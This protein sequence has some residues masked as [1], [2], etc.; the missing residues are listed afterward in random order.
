[1]TSFVGFAPADAPRYVV[2]VDLERPTGAGDG[3]GVAAPVFS[4]V[5][6][7]ALTTA[8]VVPSGTPRPNFTLIHTP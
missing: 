3:G 7:Y 8:G 6:R 2:A 4:D 1:V 5:M